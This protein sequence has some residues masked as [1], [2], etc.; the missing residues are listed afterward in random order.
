MEGRVGL[1]RL[2]EGEDEGEEE[3]KRGRDKRGGGGGER[4]GGGEYV[5]E[6]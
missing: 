3:I 1:E 5:G 6:G 2:G 4:R